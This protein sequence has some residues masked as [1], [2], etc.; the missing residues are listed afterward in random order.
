MRQVNL[1]SS[2]SRSRRMAS[3]SAWARGISS[4][5]PMPRSSMPGKMMLNPAGVSHLSPSVT[6]V[7]LCPMKRSPEV[8]TMRLAQNHSRQ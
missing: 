7:E 5:M 2:V 3:R 1:F 8:S 4:P 6:E